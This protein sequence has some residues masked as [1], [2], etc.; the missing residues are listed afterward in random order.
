MRGRGGE[1]I[2]A[3]KPTLVLPLPCVP[4]SSTF[5]F[6]IRSYKTAQPQG[7]SLVVKSRQ[8]LE[9]ESSPKIF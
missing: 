1:G 9:M 3:L 7:S 6:I 8:G 5:F 2:A 4:M